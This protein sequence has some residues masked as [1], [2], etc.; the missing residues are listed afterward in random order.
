MKAF[1][2][3]HAVNHPDMP[4]V[5]NVG[6]LVEDEVFYPGDSFTV[7]DASVGTLLVPTGAPW[8]KLAETIAYLREINPARGFSTHDGLYNDSGLGLIDN[9]LRIEAERA[10]TD[11]RRLKPGES[12][13]LG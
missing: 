5:E 8:L 3:W 11:I 10:G 6:F 4:V 12:V 13:T 9:W 7:P 2:E 1:G